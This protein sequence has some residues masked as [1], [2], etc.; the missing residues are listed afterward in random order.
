MED[1]QAL[2]SGIDGGYRWR[3]VLFLLFF[4]TADD[5]ITCLQSFL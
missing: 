4:S 2:T 5:E 1:L 3:E